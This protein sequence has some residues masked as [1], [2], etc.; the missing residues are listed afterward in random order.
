MTARTISAAFLLGVALSGAAP[1]EARGGGRGATL[2]GASAAGTPRGDGFAPDSLVRRALE[3]VFARG[4][5]ASLA[6]AYRPLTLDS[7]TMRPIAAAARSPFPDDTLRVYACRRGS[8]STSGYGVLDNV[9]GKSRD[10]TYLVALTPAGE[11][12]AVEVLVYRESHGG[13]VASPVFTGQF[14]GKKPGDR[15]MPGRDV[16]TISGATI[17]SRAI[18]GGVA[19]VLAAF[20]AV[21]GRL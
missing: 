5:S 18:A 17:S 21:K 7:A 2:T 4:D 16:R 10:I 6:I 9:R 8:D 14:A 20:S 1:P 15:L 3:R 19:R 13:E 11:V 12:S